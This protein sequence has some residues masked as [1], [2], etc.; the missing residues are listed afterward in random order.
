MT[1]TSMR[2]TAEYPWAVKRGIASLGVWLVCLVVL[3][4]FA[5][6]ALAQLDTGSIAGTILDPA[7]RVVA[8]AQVAITG[9]DTGTAYSTLSSSTGYYTFPSVHTGRYDLSVAAAG[10]KT[11]I[12]HGVVV[13]VGA[14]S[15]QDVTLAVGTASETVSVAADAQTLEADTSTIDDSIQPEQV[16]QLPLDGGRLAF[17]GNVLKPW[18]RESSALA[19]PAPVRHRSKSMAARNW[20]PT[21]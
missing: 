14:N 13:S 21:S 10:F 15:A 19:S 9:V 8:G 16:D 7:G 6:P 1:A 11:A 18:S 4:G 2:T 5:A 12:R 20:E 3:L 17:A